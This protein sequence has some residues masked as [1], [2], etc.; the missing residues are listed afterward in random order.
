MDSSFDKIMVK[1]NEIHIEFP[2]MRFGQV[3]QLAI[4]SKKQTKNFDLTNIPSKQIL[5]S[6]GEFKEVHKIKRRKKI[7]KVKK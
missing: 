2:D 1:L 7:N 5:S 4:D 6:L 3:L